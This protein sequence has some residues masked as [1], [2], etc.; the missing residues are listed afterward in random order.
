MKEVSHKIK[1]TEYDESFLYL[2]FIDIV[3]SYTTEDIEIENV[4]ISSKTI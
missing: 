4:L 2:V 3:F 1:I